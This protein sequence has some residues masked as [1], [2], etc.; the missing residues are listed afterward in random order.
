MENG[1]VEGEE[2]YVVLDVKH[3]HLVFFSAGHNL[4][5]QRRFRWTANRSKKVNTVWKRGIDSIHLRQS[6]RMVVGRS[7]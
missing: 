4:Q 6:Y 2:E 7:Q 3:L 5:S 1:L